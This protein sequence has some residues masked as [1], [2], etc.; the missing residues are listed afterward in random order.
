MIYELNSKK[1]SKD[2]IGGKA[3]NL[4]H[5]SNLNVNV[6]KWI[7][8]TS[9][10]FYEFLGKNKEQYINL[11]NNYNEINRK[12][13]IS[14]IE[15]T[16]FS[17]NLKSKILDKIKSN[18]NSND[19]LSIRSSA[20]DE[21]G[22]NF[23]FAGMLES[24]LNVEINENIFNYIK[25]CYMSCFSTRI[26][27]YRNKN[28][29]INDSISMCVIIQKMIDSDYA[30]VMFTTN[31]QTNNPDET[32]ISI[33]SG[34]GENLVSGKNDSSDYVVDCLENIISKNG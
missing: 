6:P 17:S 15:T 3:F 9:D 28:N 18:F 16:E 1:I 12:K 4:L 13:I 26:M 5:L 23:S 29:L 10:C 30:G 7:A 19:K 27:E 11:L 31:P 33:V 2:K 22:D 21:D 34:I 32:L 20:T 8:L 14:L 24:Y 25:K